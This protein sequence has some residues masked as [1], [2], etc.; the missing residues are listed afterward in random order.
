MVPQ[1]PLLF[2]SETTY[3]RPVFM[4]YWYHIRLSED[5]NEEFV[6]TVYMAW[7][8]Q[9]LIAFYSGNSYTNS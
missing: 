4:D 7:Y 6:W 1:Y 8:F 2:Y 5:R 9:S 3:G